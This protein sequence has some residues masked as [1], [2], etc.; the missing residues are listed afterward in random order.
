MY[1]T[2][3]LVL[4][5]VALAVSYHGAATEA[6]REPFLALVRELCRTPTAAELTEGRVRRADFDD[7]AG[8]DHA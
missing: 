7:A 4:A 5:V 2:L 1:R 6:E 8:R 3:A